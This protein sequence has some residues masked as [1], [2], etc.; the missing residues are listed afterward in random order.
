MTTST[1]RIALLLVAVTVMSAGAGSRLHAE[2]GHAAGVAVASA[3]ISTFRPSELPPACSAPATTLTAS[4]D[5]WVNE[6]AQTT[7]YGAATSMNVVARTGRNGRTLVTFTLP[8]APA[9]CVLASATLRIFNSATAAGRQISAYRAGGAWS[10]ATT[11]TNQPTAAG[12]AVNATAAAGW[13][14]WTVTAHVQTLYAGTNNG[15]LLRDSVEG[16]G[17]LYTNQFSTRE[18]TSNQPQLVL[19]WG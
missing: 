10:E 1:R 6:S 11:W 9:G 7:S 8:A 15:F 14:Q 16:G 19:T 13:M 4:G 5:T 2:V 18:A 17:T 12:T 3:R